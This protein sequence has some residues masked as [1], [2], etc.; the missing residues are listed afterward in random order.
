M[1]INSLWAYVLTV[2]GKHMRGPCIYENCPIPTAVDRIT[3]CLLTRPA[4]VAD[5]AH[6][7]IV[8]MSNRTASLKSQGFRVQGYSLNKNRESNGSDHGKLSGNWEQYS[9]LASQK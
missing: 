4:A 8:A 7:W 6:G 1:R 2:W 9:G 5:P 3:P